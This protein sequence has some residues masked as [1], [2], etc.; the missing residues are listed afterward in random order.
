[1]KHS[2]VVTEGPQDI[3]L[4]HRVLRLYGAEFVKLEARLDPFWKPLIPT[5]FPHRGDLTKRMPVPSF[6]SWDTH[7]VA[8]IAAEGDSGLAATAADSLEALRGV[9]DGVGVLLDADSTKPAAQRFADLRDELAQRAIILGE[10]GHAGVVTPNAGGFVLPDCARQG[11]LEDVVLAAGRQAFPALARAAEAFVD[12]GLSIDPHWDLSRSE[13]APLR[14][15]AGKNKVT[16]AIMTA[17]LK[18]GKT[19]AVTLQ[20]NAWIT[21][22]SLPTIPELVAL[23]SFLRS[24]H[25][26]P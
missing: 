26:L 3:A 12:D 2:L 6:F 18:P 24:V 4:L 8:V 1:M 13:L 17:V 21:S 14:K 22:A 7:S 11:T 15:P 5:T 9:V 16:V 20:D 19:L 10:I 23:V 25:A